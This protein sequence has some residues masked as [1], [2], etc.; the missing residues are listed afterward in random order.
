MINGLLSIGLTLCAALI[1]WNIIPL[2]V[3]ENKK[4][5]WEKVKP[6]V[7]WGGTIATAIFVVLFIVKVL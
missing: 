2:N 5:K 7:K 1:G 4:E 6:V 3:P